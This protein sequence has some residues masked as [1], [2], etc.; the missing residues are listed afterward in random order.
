MTQSINSNKK[1][2]SQTMWTT[3]G[4]LLLTVFMTLILIQ[5]HYCD[6]YCD[7][8]LECFI[9]YTQIMTSFGSKCHHLSKRSSPHFYGQLD[10]E[11]MIIYSNTLKTPF[12]TTYLGTKI[13]LSCLLFPEQSSDDKSTSS[14]FSTVQ[15]H[16][17]MLPIVSDLDELTCLPMDAAGVSVTDFK[18][19]S[20]SIPGK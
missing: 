13:F 10:I 8:H 18:I 17:L 3:P 2:I 1:K 9:S 16:P 20:N 7:P 14:S 19:L 12:L 5:R 15:S 11:K 4:K 6:A